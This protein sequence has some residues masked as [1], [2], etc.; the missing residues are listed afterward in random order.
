[1]F[2]VHLDLGDC[3]PLYEQVA[4]QIRR[5]IANGEVGPGERLP[6]ARDLAAVLKV[7]HNT[8]LRALRD[9]RDEG[10]LEFRRGRGV[11]V[12]ADAPRRGV[13][14]DKVR[15]LLRTARRLGYGK[16]EVIDLIASS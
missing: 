9:L 6:P 5:A 14:D 4:G 12:A 8:V 1:M 16:Q 10:V 7:N 2:D 3:T 15:D 11:T 13:I